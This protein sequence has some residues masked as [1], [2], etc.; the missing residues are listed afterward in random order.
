MRDF[1]Q[2]LPQAGNLF[3]FQTKKEYLDNLKI[4]FSSNT[5]IDLLVD[6]FKYTY[7]NEI[8]WQNSIV[9][10][11]IRNNVY[12]VSYIIPRSCLFLQNITGTNDNYICKNP[13]SSFYVF[14]NT[15]DYDSTKITVLYNTSTQ[16]FTNN[17]TIT[18]ITKVLNNYTQNITDLGDGFSNIKCDKYYK[19]YMTDVYTETSSTN[20]YIYNPISKFDLLSANTEYSNLLFLGYED[21]IKSGI[22]P[23]WISFLIKLK[24]TEDL[25]ITDNDFVFGYITRIDG[26]DKNRITIVKNA[27]GKGLT[28]NKVLGTINTSIVAVQRKR[29]NTDYSDIT[30]AVITGTNGYNVSFRNSRTI[31]FSESLE[32]LTYEVD[33]L[34]SLANITAIADSMGDTFEIYSPSTA[35]TDTRGVYFTNLGELQNLSSD[36]L[37]GLSLIEGSNYPSNVIDYSSFI[38]TYNTATYANI[39][40]PYYEDE[41][42]IV[43]NLHTDVWVNCN[44]T[45]SIPDNQSAA[46]DADLD[47][48]S[49]DDWDDEIKEIDA[50]TEEDDG[51]EEDDPDSEGEKDTGENEGNNTI[52]TIN[53]VFKYNMSQFET[54]W[55][56]SEAEFQALGLLINSSD[57]L[58]NI[59]TLIASVLGIDPLSGII[60]VQIA[61]ISLIPNVDLT[62]QTMCIRGIEMIGNVKFKDT[63]LKSVTVHGN[64]LEENVKEFDLGEEL[65]DE[66]FGSYMDLIDTQMTLY[67]PFVGNIDLDIRDF[68]LGKLWIKG[69]V[70]SYTGQIVYYIISKDKP[71]TKG[72]LQTKIV[73]TLTGN[74]YSTIPLTQDCYGSFMNSFTRG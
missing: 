68:Y 8:D 59:S 63:G 61:P 35:S 7:E 47:D 44:T 29:Y 72:N 52:P 19:T 13:S 39:N 48:V 74:C 67:L 22:D 1:V 16:D 24:I 36:S 4:V 5:Y 60:S 40:N 62:L 55:L 11:N 65:I 15:E 18:H 54:Q 38:S 12:L 51:E 30:P 20:Q 33:S 71:D 46:Q 2:Y 56:L 3:T 21:L 64:P 14:N 70:E 6:E 69:F 57:F 73:S 58:Q 26:V 25:T 9:L 10:T 49:D 17:K 34:Y 42:L 37:N 31:I 45:K 66:K 50:S 43:T 28:C 32:Y 53:D 41:E 27:K 23:K